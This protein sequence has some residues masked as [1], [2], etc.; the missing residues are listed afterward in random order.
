M[1]YEDEEADENDE[2]RARRDTLMNRRLRRARGEED[3]D[4]EYEAYPAAYGSRDR[5]RYEPPIYVTPGS[6]AG[7]Q[8]FFGLLITA[9]VIIL[10]LLFGP[11][12]LARFATGAIVNPVQQAFAT[13]T[14]T[15]IDRA[16]TLRQ[17]RSLNRL[18]TQSF[19]I[20]TVVEAS[21]QR[22][23]PL[24][25]LLGD[26]LLLIASGEVIAGIDL[27]KIGENDIVVSADGE[28]VTIQLPPSEIFTVSLNEQRTRVYERS[29]GPLAPRN[30][31]LE[32]EARRRAVDEIL[33]AAC[34]GAIMQKAADD[35]RRSVEQLLGAL[36]FTSVIVEVA[37][38][39][40]IAPS[41]T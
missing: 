8:L 3:E 23:N 29:S 40:C 30:A 38:G 25:L 26:K 28:S 37:A 18:E 12:L 19:S 2:R 35:G 6:G 7:A 22:N 27:S 39:S 16:T 17:I 41:G 24:D 20:E 11:Q 36:G 1:T 34:E 14:P 13:P 33:G 21:V 4:I 15:I 31:N 10:G 9:T 5:S 32:T